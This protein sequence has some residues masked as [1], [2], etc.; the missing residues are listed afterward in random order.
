MRR[1]ALTPGYRLLPA[2]DPR[3]A[4]DA[5]AAPDALRCR[6]G[7][8]VADAQTIE[9]ASPHVRGASHPARPADA[10]RRARPQPAGDRR[11]EGFACVR[12]GTPAPLAAR[13]EAAA[14]D[15]LWGAITSGPPG[16]SVSIDFATAENQWAIRVGLAAGLTITPKGTL[17]VRGEV[18]RLAPYLPS[19]AYL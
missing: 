18:G 3:G 8:V 12:S 11:R 6:P 5:R 4:P 16:G 17:F 14:E 10:P 7:D 1:Y 19:G 15:L 2:V 9:A 13:N